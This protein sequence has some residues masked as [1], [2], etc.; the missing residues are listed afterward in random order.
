MSQ[1]NHCSTWKCFMS[2]FSAH[3]NTCKQ[4]AHTV[5]TSEYTLLYSWPPSAYCTRTRAHDVLLH[6]D[7]AVRM[8]LN[9]AAAGV[10]AA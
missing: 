6:T 2:K 10:G 8:L 1:K 4:K 7:C 5:R 9:N 3:K